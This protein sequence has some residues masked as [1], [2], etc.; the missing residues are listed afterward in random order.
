M[1]ETKNKKIVICDIDG[2]VSDSR[3]RVKKYL[4]TGFECEKCGVHKYHSELVSPII[5][6]NKCDEYKGAG[7]ICDGNIVERKKDWTGFYDKVQEDS[8]IET[9][10]DMVKNIK[11]GGYEIVFVTGRNEVCRVNTVEWLKRHFNSTEFDLIMRA[12]YDR[13]PSAQVKKAVVTNMFNPKDIAFVL[14]DEPS[15]IDMYRKNCPNAT[16]I[17]VKNYLWGDGS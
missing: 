11:M 3:D 17:D 8:P 10:V 5:R 16:I 4:Y 7:I 12:S 9:M 13:R 6:I 1:S 14:D 2:V 15:V